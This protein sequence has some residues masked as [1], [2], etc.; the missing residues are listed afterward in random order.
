[1]YRGAQAFEELRYKTDVYSKEN[2]RPIA[3]MLTIGNLTMRKARSQFSCNFFAIAGLSVIDNNGFDSVDE[4]VKATKAAGAD[5]VVICSSDDEYKSLVPEIAEKLDKEIVV[6]AGNPTCKA[7][8]EEKG[9]T[10]FIHVKSNLLEEL[11]A[12]QSK[13]GI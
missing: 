3:F 5:I 1:P 8:L 12:Y 10:N 11:M 7:E 2:K 4:G 6:V 9:I 13:L